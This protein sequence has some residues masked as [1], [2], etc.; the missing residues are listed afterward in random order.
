M[1][2][3]YRN[4]I[5]RYLPTHFLATSSTNDSDNFGFQSLVIIDK[6]CIRALE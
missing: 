1:E 2:I 3:T 5:N 6:I 4:N